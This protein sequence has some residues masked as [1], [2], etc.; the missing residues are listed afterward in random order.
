MSLGF[1]FSFKKKK[2]KAKRDLVTV[3]MLPF[4]E[5]SAPLSVNGIA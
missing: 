2:G 3:V 4:T 5:G 1:F